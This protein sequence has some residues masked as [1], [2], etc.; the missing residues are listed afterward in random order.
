MPRKDYFFLFD[1]ETTLSDKVADFGAVIVDKKGVI[2]HQCAVLVDGVFGVDALFYKSGSPD[3]D[4]WS[5]QGKDR[6]FD[7][8]QEMLKEGTRILASVAAINRWIEQ[9]IG[10]YDPILTAYNLPFDVSKC[11]NT[12]IDVNKFSQRFCMWRAAAHVWGPTKKFKQYVLDNHAFNHPTPYNNM[13]FKTNAEIMACFLQ[14]IPEIVDEPHTSIEDVID[15]ELPILKALVKKVPKKVY[16]D[17]TLTYNWRNFQ[18]KEHF[19]V[20]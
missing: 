12:G 13:S 9:A 5:K 16:L 1:T 8:Y 3:T 20:K 6:R 17:P 7:A 18:V 10:K 19:T 2:H 15:Y 14:D 4:I 11:R